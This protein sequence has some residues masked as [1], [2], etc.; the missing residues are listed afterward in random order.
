MKHLIRKERKSQLR[1]WGRMPEKEKRMVAARIT[2]G[3]VY[4]VRFLGIRRIKERSGIRAKTRL[5]PNLPV[6]LYI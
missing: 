4:L 3:R 6:R 5:R 2:P 1:T